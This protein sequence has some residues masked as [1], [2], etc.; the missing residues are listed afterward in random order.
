MFFF[1]AL[2]LSQMGFHA[3]V[4][5]LERNI[6]ERLSIAKYCS[7]C[8]DF[9]LLKK[10][11]ATN[12]IFL[13]KE[14]FNKI[15]IPD[16]NPLKEYWKLLCEHTHATKYSIQRWIDL[17]D[18]EEYKR[19]LSRFLTLLI[20]LECNYHLL[21]TIIIDDQVEYLGRTFIPYV[22]GNPYKIPELKIKAHELFRKARGHFKQPAKCLI[23]T[24][25]RKWTLK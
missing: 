10:W 23:Y 24:Y 2:E 14:V 22:Y 17:S 13:T 11:T 25:K 18:E 16:P 7:I 21:N 15:I 8:N 19:V 12:H 5:P 4:M 3:S 1:S 9:S 6:F 20:L